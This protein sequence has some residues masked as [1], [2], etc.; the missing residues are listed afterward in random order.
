MREF[1]YSVDRRISWRLISL[2]FVAKVMVWL[3]L[4]I[5]R[6]ASKAEGDVKGMEFLSAVRHERE[7]SNAGR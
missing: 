5:S 2:E 1:T 6:L 7:I 3:I 4:C